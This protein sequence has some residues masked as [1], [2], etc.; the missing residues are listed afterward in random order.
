MSA[1]TEPVVRPPHP[2]AVRLR[3]ALQALADALAHVQLDGLLAAETAMVDVLAE[4]GRLSPTT[5][6]DR[7]ATVRELA[8]ARA[9]LTRCRRLGTTMGEVVR[10]SL[11]AQGRGEAY[12]P[13]YATR[14]VVKVHSLEAKA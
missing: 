4:V 9:T 13:R 12:G 1:V 6:W 10:L 2:T 3:A 11:T 5:E 8:A 7:Q 14:E